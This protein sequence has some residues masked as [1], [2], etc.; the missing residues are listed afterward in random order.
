VPSD[1]S[2]NLNL[3]LQLGPAL[4]SMQCLFEVLKLLGALKKFFD[5]ASGGLPKIPSAAGE[6]VAAFDG[7]AKCIAFPLG[8][9]AFLFVRD[10]LR[11]IGKIL[12]CL[13]QNL[14]S[15]AKLMG[16]LTL[17]IDNARTAG[18]TDLLAALECAQDNARRSAQGALMAIEPIT[19]VLGM[20]EPFMGV[21]GVS[22]IKLPSIGDLE[23]AQSLD[24]T[25]DA[26]LT[27]SA[28]LL[29]IAD[30]I[31]VPS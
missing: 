13:G 14:K 7:V 11:L 15:I 25:A 19:L 20:A 27:V 12:R 10:L 4:A 16:G 18:N 21:A 29:T 8:S 28:T 5:A 6:V 22:P 3:M 2:L 23:D 17:Q 31:Q 24:T 30:G 1:C 9:G 26:L